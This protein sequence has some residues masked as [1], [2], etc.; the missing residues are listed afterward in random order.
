[1]KE[2]DREYAIKVSEWFKQTYR[3]IYRAGGHP[4][5]VIDKFPAELIDILTRNNLMI[6]YKT[7]K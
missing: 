1:M 7:P 4:P 5:T 2:E 3:E 6:T